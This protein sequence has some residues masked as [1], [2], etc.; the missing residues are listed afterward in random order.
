[1]LEKANLVDKKT[2]KGQ[3]A[4]KQKA[5]INIKNKQK[6]ESSN[7]NS[8]T[9]QN[10][11][12]QKTKENLI[13]RSKTTNEALAK[14][15]TNIS[16]E[17]EAINNNLSE[18][19]L[20]S[21][22]RNNKSTLEKKMDSAIEYINGL[23]EDHI[24]EYTKSVIRD[25]LIFVKKVTSSNNENEDLDSHFQ[26][27][28]KIL[29]NIYKQM[30]QLALKLDIRYLNEFIPE[31]IFIQTFKIIIVAP[32]FLVDVE[33]YLVP[34]IVKIRKILDNDIKFY[35]IYFEILNKFI[36]FDKGSSFLQD[37][38]PK[39]TYVV[40][41]EFFLLNEA[42]FDREILEKFEPFIVKNP[43][44]S[45][46]EKEKYIKDFSQT[47][48]IYEILN[49]NNHSKNKHHESNLRSDDDQQQENSDLAEQECEARN[50]PGNNESIDENINNN[51]KK[52]DNSHSKF[53]NVTN[54]GFNQVKHAHDSAVKAN[55]EDFN[56]DNYNNNNNINNKEI[57]NHT[58]N[59]TKNRLNTFSGSEN[60]NSNIINNNNNKNS[61]ND[62]EEKENFRSNN[63]VINTLT[64]TQARDLEKEKEKPDAQASINAL[65]SSVGKLANF[66]SLTA[67]NQDNTQRQ[68]QTSE[69]D[70]IITSNSINS[71]ISS[72]KTSLMERCRK[73]D[74]NIKRINNKIENDS[75]KNSEIQ[76]TDFTNKSNKIS[77]NQSDNSLLNRLDE[78]KNRMQISQSPI[79]AQNNLLYKPKRNLED[80]EKIEEVELVGLDQDT[81]PHANVEAQA[82]AQ[83]SLNKN[84][85]TPKLNNYT[86]NN[87]YTNNMNY[88][89]KSYYQSEK[90]SNLLI[91]NRLDENNF[92]NI[93][94]N[95]S[96]I[97]HNNSN[98]HDININTNNINEN[99]L[100]Y[101]SNREDNYYT[102]NKNTSISNNNNIDEIKKLILKIPVIIL[103]DCVSEISHYV[104]LENAFGKM[105]NTTK[106]EFSQFLCDSINNV[107]LIKTC[108]FNC[109]LQLLEFLLSLLIKVNKSFYF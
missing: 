78:Y 64:K 106:L 109:F 44:F 97:S 41:F 82:D 66:T 105:S 81:H 45:N 57:N 65:E 29:E 102:H 107:S 79:P 11:K 27:I 32:C 14:K 10:L 24:F 67:S 18:S 70:L 60:I 92:S 33:T 34:F 58:N 72:I 20:P 61:V 98:T 1:M 2:P 40:F 30:E 9:K 84:F 71:D 43:F 90:N 59:K 21:T 17:K 56:Y 5:E 74:M 89:P 108:S 25:F 93:N 54:E 4:K 15:Q 31:E 49:K 88:Y 91:K 3:N 95:V 63:I 87:N 16:S 76:T 52:L 35:E 103:D 23:H 100:S 68:G 101:S 39:N 19:N 85:N 48:K 104:L 75:N 80:L 7:S 26:V 12:A 37:I 55:E 62:P 22:N 86:S 51:S 47:I 46:E 42:A 28:L 13:K 50:S 83:Y 8:N 96:N 77:T 99:F 38:N 36:S 94:P 6:S 69:K 73:I 53:Q